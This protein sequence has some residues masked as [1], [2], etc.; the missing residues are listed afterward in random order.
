MAATQPGFAISTQ[1]NPSLL[2]YTLKMAWWGKEIQRP[3]WEAFTEKRIATQRVEYYQEMQPVGMGGAKGEGA[4]L[5]VGTAGEAWKTSYPSVTYGNSIYITMEDLQDNLYKKDWNP[6]SMGFADA[7]DVL[8]YIT[9]FGIFNH[10]KV[11][12]PISDGAGSQGGDGEPLLSVSHPIAEGNKYANTWATGVALGMQTYTQMIEGI[13]SFPN[14]V[15]WILQY[16]P[17]LMGVPIQN[18]YTA[19][20]LMFSPDDPS[21]ANR[22][23]NANFGD[24]FKD[25][26][27]V[28]SYFRDP[29][30]FWGFSSTDHGFAFFRRMDFTIQDLPGTNTLVYGYFGVERFAIGYDSPTCVY[31][32]TQFN[33]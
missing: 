29:A 25:G 30:S 17:R 7:Q 20:M 33:T 10:A 2:L 31:G 23:I 24:Y 3:K 27:F 16:T 26:L 9:I 21:T 8:R 18:A 19:K 15:G 32:S 13:Q 11:N 6:R 22:S 4:P 12:S 1:N 14:Y 28:S 5:P